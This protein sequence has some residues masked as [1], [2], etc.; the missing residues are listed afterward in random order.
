MTCR[1][2]LLILAVSCLLL[3]AL[4]ARGAAASSDL[5]NPAALRPQVEFWKTVFAVY[6]EHQVLIHDSEH[7]DRVYTVLD[8][9]EEAEAGTHPVALERMRHQGVDAEKR[10][11][12]LLLLRLQS[13]GPDTTGLTK[14]ERAIRALFDGDRDP[15]RFAKAAEPDRIRAQR[16]LKERFREGVRVSRRYL[17][18]MERIFAD[19]G[20]PKELTRLPLVES[21]FD[22]DAYSKVGAAGIWQFMPATGRQYMRVDG[23]VDER[24]DPLRATRAAARHLTGDHAALGTWPL[25]LTAYN[26]GAGGVRRAVRTMGTTD[27]A[28][29]VRGYR[30][31]RFGF[32]SRNFYVEFLAAVEVEREYRSHFGDLSFDPPFGGDEVRLRHAVSSKAA[33]TCAGVSV[34]DLATLNPAVDAGVFH[35]GR[36]L[37]AGYVLRVPAGSSGSFERRLAAVPASRRV[38]AAPRA[39]THRVARGQTLSHIASRYGV[40]VGALQR[41]NAL[42]GTTIRVGQT[43]RIPAKGG[44]AQRQAV[45]AVRTHRVQRGQTLS[46]LASRYGVSVRELQRANS[47]RSTTVRAGQVLRIPAS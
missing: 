30:G 20:L 14:E 31:P 1:S 44:A 9:R 41:A 27:I 26:H 32:A 28:R 42:R 34:S 2:K 33:A 47:L 6:S 5:P 16:G 43:L 39:G 19:E 45:A 40:S 24:R 17:P 18:T 3:L 37:P 7:L 38:V 23:V 21:C 36:N 29:I 35:R 4:D 8:Y 12:R 46:H 13:K 15:R 10:R 11:I 22:I 25:A